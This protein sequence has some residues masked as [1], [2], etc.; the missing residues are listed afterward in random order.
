MRRSEV[1]ALL[2]FVLLA[3]QSSLGATSFPAQLKLVTAA[4]YL[5]QVPFL[6]RVEAFNAQGLPDRALWNAEVALSVDRP[7][8]SLSTNAVTLRNGRGSVL[9]V[10]EG[11]G[12][13]TLEAQS[14]AISVSRSIRDRSGEAVATVGGALP[15]SETIWSGVILITNDVTVP[16]GHTLTILSNTLVL[17]DGVAS[18]TTA[19]DLLVRGTVQSL[20]TE[21]HPVTFTCAQS[22][23]RWGQIRHTNAQPSVYRHT[24]VTRAGRGRT[25]GHTGTTPV[26]RPF[27]SRLVFEHCSLTDFADASG[28][29]GKIGQASGS[30]LT[31]IDC[32]FQRARMGPEISG[33]A[34]ACT[35]TWILDMNGPDDADGIYLHDQSAGQQVTLSGCV[36]ALG[37]DDGIDT[38]GSVIT[39]EK[40]IVRDW[41]S[42]VEDAKGVSVFSG[43]THVRDSLIVD[44]TVGI[45][46]KTS[47]SASVLVTMNH[48]TLHG[49]Q[50][51]V[52]AQFKSNA[53]GPVVDYRITNCVLWAS[54]VSVQSDFAETNFTIRYSA[55]AQPWPGE[56]NAE[57]DPMFVDEA[58][59]DFHLL[60]YSPAIDS[61]DPGSPFD[62]DGSRADR[63]AFTFIPPSPVLSGSALTLGNSFQFLLHA[64]TNR[65]YVI[66]SSP[67]SA[68]WTFL[69][70]VTQP[71]ETNLVTDTSN[72]GVPYRFYRARLAP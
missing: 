56:G 17:L 5:P 52:L 15:G 35:N 36:L 40:C 20:G 2:T 28:T 47:A 46:A 54:P 55:I 41:N 12:D 42:R 53:P 26:I 59:H 32:L 71:A 70:T 63:G 18:G 48:C 10:V 4:G 61:G 39:V 14:G 11:G 43:Q 62:P 49:N 69:K 72:S 13:F 65:S 31:F 9:I 22:E 64:Y 57:A 3:L 6:V 16:V 23:L 51:N 27:N 58:A 29:P 44:C 38:L 7:G 67:D 33:T 1:S 24:I 8:I 50:T 25:E 34:L 60:P 30:D 45:A 19:N 21:A 37:G 68:T 66:E